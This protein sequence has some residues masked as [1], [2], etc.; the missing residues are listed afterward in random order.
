MS[1]D[2]R[3]RHDRSLRERTAEM[4][5]GGLGYGFVAR[6]L[7]VPAEAVRDWQKT[8]PP[9][10]PCEAP[11][12]AEGPDP[13]GVP[14]PGPSGGRLAVMIYRV[15][16][17]GRSLTRCTGAHSCTHVRGCRRAGIPNGHAWRHDAWRRGQ[18][19]WRQCQATRGR[20]WPRRASRH[21]CREP[22]GLLGPACS[23]ARRDSPARRAS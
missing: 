19:P 18:G 17:L 9:L 11:G 15:Q 3:L 2:L 23:A 12:Q 10:E 21:R 7:G 5:E 22:S 14:G 8:H 16:V 4:F 13:G 6:G 20:P 1:V